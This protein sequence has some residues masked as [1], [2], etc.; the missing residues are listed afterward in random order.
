MSHSD[1]PRYR[2]GDVVNGWRLTA[3]DGWVPAGRV[4][5][6]RARWDRTSKIIMV[7]VAAFI[8]A[9]NG[10]WGARQTCCSSNGHG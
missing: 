5:L 10:M 9:A 6:P 2:P 4:P 1:P 8:R 3:H 7:G